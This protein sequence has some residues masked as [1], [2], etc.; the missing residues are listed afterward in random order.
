MKAATVTEAKNGLSALL[1][2][3]RAGESVVIT[4]RGIPIARLEPVASVED[5]SGRIKRLQRAGV[6]AARG[7]EVPEAILV[8]PPPRLRRVVDAVEDLIE[9]RR[10]GR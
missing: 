4:D 7:G 9:D 6:V 8:A 3:V 10:Q 5:A 2:R 1:D